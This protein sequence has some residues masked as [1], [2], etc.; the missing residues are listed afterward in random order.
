VMEEAERRPLLGGLREE[1]RSEARVRRPA[2][3]GPFLGVGVGV[4]G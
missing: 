1:A 4:R 3:D 2:R